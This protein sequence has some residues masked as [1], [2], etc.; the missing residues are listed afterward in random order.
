MTQGG[1][2]YQKLAIS[3]SVQLYDIVIY[4]NSLFSY[5]VY[6]ILH[7]FTAYRQVFSFNLTS[8]RIM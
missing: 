2:G 6:I 8:G 3:A 7:N 5:I 1:G 4:E